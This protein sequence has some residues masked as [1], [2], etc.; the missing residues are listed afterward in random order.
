MARIEV[1]EDRVVIQLTTSEK[2]LAMRRR[3]VVIERSAITSA[4]ITDDPWIWIRGVRSPGTH[5]PGTLAFGTWR[6]LGGRDFVLARSKRRAIVIDL[7][8]DLA[9][10]GTGAHQDEEDGEFD[11]FSRVILSTSHAA[12]LITALRLE[13]DERSVHSTA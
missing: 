2:A 1:H 4:L 3:D 7:D 8:Q 6:N 9:R 10:A 13:G 11:D 5:V 12:E